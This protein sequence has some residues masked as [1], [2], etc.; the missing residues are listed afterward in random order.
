MHTQ[1]QEKWVQGI[2]HVLGHGSPP[3]S[4]DPPDAAR[5]SSKK[6]RKPSYQDAH[7]EL[8]VDCVEKIKPIGPDGWDRVEK[9]FNNESKKHDWPLRTGTALRDQWNKVCSAVAQKLKQQ[10]IKYNLLNYRW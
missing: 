4:P 3:F 1:E 8:I 10:P 2:G 6:G 7:L 9:A 5:P